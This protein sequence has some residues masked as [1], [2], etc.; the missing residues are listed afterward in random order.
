MSAQALVVILCGLLNIRSIIVAGVA[1]GISIWGK[2]LEAGTWVVFITLAFVPAILSTLAPIVRFFSLRYWISGGILHLKHGWLSK[3]TL[4]IPLSRIHSLS[5]QS[6]IWYQATD[7]IG[8][9]IDTKATDDVELELILTQD[10][11]D[12]LSQVITQEEQV[13]LESS[14]Q[15]GDEKA[16]REEDAHPLEDLRTTTDEH[17]DCL[18]SDTTRRKVISYRLKDLIRAGLTGNYLKG[19]W[20]IVYL[21]YKAFDEL[22]NLLPDSRMVVER[23]ITY[24]YSLGHSSAAS[25]WIGDS[26][27]IAIGV[28]LIVLVSATIQAG[29]YVWRYWQSQIEITPKRIV[30]SRGLSTRIKQTVRRKQAISVSFTTNIL[31]YLLGSKTLQVELARSTSTRK[32][33]NRFRLRG[34]QDQAS[35]LDWWQVYDKDLIPTIRSRW[36]I[37]RLYILIGIVGAVCVGGFITW[38]IYREEATPYWL[39]LSG[40]PLCLGIGYGWSLYRLS[41]IRLTP[42]HIHLTLGGWCKQ[43]R[44]I[45]YET[46]NMVAIHQAIW[47]KRT[48]TCSLEIC[49][50]GSSYRIPA[51]NRQKANE[52]RNA[53]LYII[54][55]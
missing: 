26:L 43:E 3:K 32:D 24:G 11:Y 27:S 51:L 44:W 6:N 42:K 4:T 17:N 20:I 9:K 13:Y 39:A 49:T 41:S 1:I 50:L 19:F 52:L 21:V 28:I 37:F 22:Y 46:V 38:L 48:D 16:P 47:Q 36:Y 33:D 2:N 14:P 18:T 10:E 15:E 12:A 54:E 8:L 7:M 25:K 55:V 34:W 29:I 45:P 23:T 30:F 31:E 40:V 35:I 53:L 5:T